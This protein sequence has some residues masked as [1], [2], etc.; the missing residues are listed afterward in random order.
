MVKMSTAKHKAIRTSICDMNLS[1]T[2]SMS[3]SLSERAAFCVEGRCR[4]VLFLYVYYQ[5]AADRA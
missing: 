3:L 4:L 5:V 2:F 1:F